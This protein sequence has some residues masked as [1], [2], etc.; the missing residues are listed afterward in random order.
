MLETIIALLV[1]AMTCQLLL[2]SVNHVKAHQEPTNL[3]QLTQLLLNDELQFQ[4]V[5]GKKHQLVL[6]SVKH[7]EVYSLEQYHNQLCLKKAGKGYMPIMYH[8]DDFQVS[9]HQPYLTIKI[10]ANKHKLEQKVVIADVK[11]KKPTQKTKPTSNDE[12]SNWLRSI[13][14]Y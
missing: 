14:W 9:Y 13:D 1:T 3:N 7:Q 2:F 8:I 6:Y 12:A 5:G 11:Q 4:Y 10:I